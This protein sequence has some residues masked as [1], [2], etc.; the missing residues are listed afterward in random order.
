MP[1][2]KKKSRR[3]SGHRAAAR[4]WSRSKRPRSA[5]PATTHLNELTEKVDIMSSELAARLA[6]VEHLLVDK[7]VCS[8]DELIR[9]RQF[10]DPRQSE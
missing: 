6:A 2:K 5:P 10:I 7:Q 4:K 8:R 3:Q 1:P 9:S